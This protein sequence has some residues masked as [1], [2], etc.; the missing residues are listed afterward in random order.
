MIAALALFSAIWM[1]YHPKTVTQAHETVVLK[2]VP[3]QTIY[4]VKNC[5]VEGPTPST[6]AIPVASGVVPVSLW[7]GEVVTNLTPSNGEMTISYTPKTKPLFGFENDK[8]IGIRYNALQGSVFGR[9][10]FV[11]VGSFYG[12]LYVE[13]ATDRHAFAG[14]ELSYRW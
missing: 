9:W 13:G 3:G 14:A 12:A 1:W 5:I 11:R 6:G 8:E 2:S 4:R 7:G 10:T